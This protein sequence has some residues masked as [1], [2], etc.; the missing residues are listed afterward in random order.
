M[1]TDVRRK[2]IAE[3]LRVTQPGG[4][5]VFVDYHKPRAWSPW[6][7]LM[8][9]VLTT[10]EPFAMDVWNHEIASWLPE[11]APVA[12]IDKKTYFGGLYQKVVMTKAA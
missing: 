5:L 1:P 7:Y 10:L 2:T 4:K 3:A 8:V 12:R 11:G 6:R 9:P